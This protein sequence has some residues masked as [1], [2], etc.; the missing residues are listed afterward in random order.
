VNA[1]TLLAMPPTQMDENGQAAGT[2]LTEVA[3]VAAKDGA[4]RVIGSV[5]AA[6]GYCA[7]TEQRLACPTATGLQVWDFS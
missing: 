3:K 2:G 4:R 6:R 5:P 1:D 7:A